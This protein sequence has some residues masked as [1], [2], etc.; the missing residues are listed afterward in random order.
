VRWTGQRSIFPEEETNF[1]L[2]QSVQ[3]VSGAHA[4]RILWVKQAVYNVRLSYF[5]SVVGKYIKT[6]HKRDSKMHFSIRVFCIPHPLS[7]TCF[8]VRS[9]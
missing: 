8:D 6:T 4:D 7:F 5:Y 3:T 2:F 1:F 9:L